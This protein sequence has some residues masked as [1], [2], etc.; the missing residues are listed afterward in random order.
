MKK[1]ILFLAALLLSGCSEASSSSFPVSIG[2][3]SASSDKISEEVH[4]AFHDLTISKRAIEMG[5]TFLYDDM[6]VPYV[7]EEDYD[8]EKMIPGDCI[9]ISFEGTI[10]FRETYPETADLANAT[11]KDVDVFYSRIETFVYRNDGIYKDGQKTVFSIPEDVIVEGWK[12]KDAGAL[13]EGT[14][15]YGIT[16]ASFSSHNV[17]YFTT[18]QPR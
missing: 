5:H 2:N 17:L 12:M 6:I 7:D 18:F 15:L 11:I 3:G 13:E 1:A 14:T 8:F 4:V 10:Y 9:S 16:P